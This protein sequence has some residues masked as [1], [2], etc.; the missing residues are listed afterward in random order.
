MTLRLPIVRSAAGLPAYCALMA[1]LFT[2]A[3]TGLHSAAILTGAASMAT[4]GIFDF[5][6]KLRHGGDWPSGWRY[7]LLAATVTGALATVMVV[8][9]FLALS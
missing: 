9:T 1:M 8:T 3:G 2:A 7:I 4:L 5:A 6:V